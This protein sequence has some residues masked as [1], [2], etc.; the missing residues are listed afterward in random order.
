MFS[1]QALLWCP[2]LFFIVS[3]PWGLC[4]FKPE[5]E[6]SLGQPNLWLGQARLYYII[7][8]IL[9]EKVSTPFLYGVD[10]MRLTHFQPQE[11]WSL[12]QP[13]MWLGWTRLQYI[14]NFILW[15]KVSTPF[16][17]GVD[18]MRL[19]HFQPPGKMITHSTQ[20]VAG[21]SETSIHKNKI[22]VKLSCRPHII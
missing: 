12:A 13:N 11:E 3:T 1:I 14:R 8:F 7:N 16:L 18:S 19:T 6:W 5:A 22:N 15:E 20:P 17:Y 10:S 4:I 9:W 21:S 2:L